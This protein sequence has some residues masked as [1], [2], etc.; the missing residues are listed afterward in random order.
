MKQGVFTQ[1]GSISTE[2]TEAARRFMSA[3]PPRA[4]KL[5]RHNE[6]SRCAN[7]DRTHRSKKT[8]RSP[9]RRGR[10]PRDFAERVLRNIG[11]GTAASVRFDVARPD[12]LTPLLGFVGDEL[13]EVRR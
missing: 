12:H 4:T 13:A 9:R 3:M 1:P 8:S 6:L 7:S 5:V 10:T 11:S 2:L